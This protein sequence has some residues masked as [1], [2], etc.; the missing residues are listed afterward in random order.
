MGHELSEEIPLVLS[1]SLQRRES[2]TEILSS[3][4]VGRRPGAADG[5]STSPDTSHG[6]ASF[7]TEH[8]TNNVYT[9]GFTTSLILAR[10]IK[11]VLNYELNFFFADYYLPSAHT[12]S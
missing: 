5:S 4:A 12:V 1:K 8:G 11:T 9:A 3:A 6:G 10:G 7:S 2:D